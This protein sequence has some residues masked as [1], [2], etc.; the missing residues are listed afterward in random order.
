MLGYRRRDVE[1]DLDEIVAAV[2][3]ELQDVGRRMGYVQIWKRLI[4]DHE[5]FVRR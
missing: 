5:L 4:R 2:E 1:S 3:F